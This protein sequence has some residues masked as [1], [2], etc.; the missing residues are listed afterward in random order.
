MPRL[1]PLVEERA[2]WRTL[3]GEHVLQLHDIGSAEHADDPRTFHHGQ[4]MDR[5]GREMVEHGAR[6]FVLSN[7]KHGLGHDGLDSFAGQQ[8]GLLQSISWT[9]S[10]PA[11]PPE[12]FHFQVQERRR[13][14]DEDETGQSL[15]ATEE[16]QRPGGSQVAEADG[17][18]RDGREIDGVADRKFKPPLQRIPVRV[19][20]LMSSRNLAPAGRIDQPD[21]SNWC[22]QPQNPSLITT[23]CPQSA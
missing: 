20:S 13:P 7:G 17:G 11:P 3:A 6:T 12:L 18:E 15:G 23:C 22:Y 1:H 9:A 5:V 16:A 2:C 21:A 14:R 8:A 4:M 10:L 19:A